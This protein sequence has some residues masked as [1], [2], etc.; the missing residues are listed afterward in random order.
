[1]KTQLS[2][3]PCNKGGFNFCCCCCLFVCLFVCLFMCVCV[4]VCV[5]CCCFF[6]FFWGGVVF[7]LFL[8]LLFLVLHLSLVGNSGRLN[9]VRLQQPQEQRY[10][11]LT[12]LTVFS[13]V[14]TKVW[15]PMLG[16]FYMRTDVYACDCTRRGVVWTL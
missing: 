14:Q 7:L 4:C 16:I 2:I 12:V 3:L 9:W 15:L 1:M 11:F 8:L 5:C 10:P 13:C 6:C